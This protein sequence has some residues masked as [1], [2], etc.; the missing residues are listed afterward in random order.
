M[1]PQIVYLISNL[2]QI[3]RNITKHSLNHKK[4]NFICIFQ[5]LI[6]LTLQT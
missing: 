4:V 5:I 1:P 6:L 2:I 3:K